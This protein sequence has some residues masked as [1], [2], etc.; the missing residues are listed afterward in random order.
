MALKASEVRAAFKYLFPAELPALQRLVNMLPDHPVVVNIGAGAGTSGL[1]IL[2]TR[3]DVTLYTIDVQDESSP[4]GCLEGER[5]VVRRAGLG[6]RWD[7]T[8]FQIQGDSKQVAASWHVVPV[9]LVFVDGDHSYEGC[10]GD[11]EGWMPRIR[12]GGIIAIHDY[13]KAEIP[14]TPDGPHPMPW[15]GVDRAVADLLLG[16]YEI[17][18]H[19]DSLIAFWV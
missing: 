19:V 5:D 6:A 11:I 14:E 12:Q 16:R 8:W 3:P 13:R 15:P 1:A 17:A 4:F 9:D 10:V 2:E 18:V 7:H